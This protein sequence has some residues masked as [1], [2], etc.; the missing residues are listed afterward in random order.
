MRYLAGHCE[1]DCV[2][3]LRHWVVSAWVEHG[4]R[5]GHGASPAEE[6]NVSRTA[7]TTGGRARPYSD[8]GI[9]VP[10]AGEPRQLGRCSAV[11]GGRRGV[12]A[13]CDLDTTSG[14]VPGYPSR[15]LT[16]KCETSA[17]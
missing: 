4:P 6:A 5:R 3:A 1:R 17:P 11:G 12:G 10:R 2:C 14:L 8:R 13:E 16:R 9:R 7:L 15:A